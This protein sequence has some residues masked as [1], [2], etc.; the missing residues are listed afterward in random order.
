MSQTPEP[1]GVDLARVALRAAREAAKKNGARTAKSKPRLTR[2]VRRDGR[3][4]MGLGE[5]FTALMAERGWENPAAMPPAGLSSPRS[6]SPGAAS[7]P[8]APR[9]SPPRR[10]VRRGRGPG[11]SSVRTAGRRPRIISDA[12]RAARTEA[13]RTVRVLLPGPLPATSAAAALDL[14]RTSTPQGPVSTRETAA[15][16]YRRALEAH[17][18]AHTQQQP[19]RAIADAVERQNRFLRAASHR[20]FPESATA[21]GVD[22]PAPIDAAHA[23]RRHDAEVVR[24]RALHQA[25]AERAGLAQPSCPSRSRRRLPG[26]IRPAEPPVREGGCLRVAVHPRV[27]GEHMSPVR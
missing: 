16:G 21:T 1:S 18:Q 6:W 23:Q 9:R 15:A 19:D 22:Q 4:P 8:R 2:T 26:W 7:T 5:A 24:L 12:N 10:H 13:V 25:R 17:Q 3:A 14:V 11:P 27:S 20:Q